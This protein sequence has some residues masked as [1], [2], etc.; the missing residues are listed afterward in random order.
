MN[1]IIIQGKDQ[2][3]SPMIISSHLLP[4]TLKESLNPMCHIR[5]EAVTQHLKSIFDHASKI[6]S[7]IA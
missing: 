5:L 3:A 2:W 1:D 7:Q 4:F 6:T